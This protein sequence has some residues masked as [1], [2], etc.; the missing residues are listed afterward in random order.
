[1]SN[2]SYPYLWG[3]DRIN[4]PRLP[5]D[6]RTS[7]ASCY[8]AAGAGVHVFV[9][10]TG[11]TPSHEQF[12]HLGDRL[13]IRAAPG[14]AFPSGVDDGRHG[15]HVAATIAGAATG[16]APRVNLTCIKVLKAD[17]SGSSLDV[18]A[19]LDVVVAWAAAHPTVPAVLSASFGGRRRAGAPDM[20]AAAAARV[21]AAGVVFVGSAGN[22]GD[23][24]CAYTPAVEPSVVA[25]A[26]AAVDDS[27]AD[28]SN[29]GACV[30]L[31]APGTRIVSADAASA[32]GRGLVA[33]TGTSMAAPHVSGLAALV[34]GEVGRRL[35]LARLLPALNGGGVTAAGLPLAWVDPHVCDWGAL[36]GNGTEVV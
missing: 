22:E 36:R 21:T 33:M 8:P 27:L 32:D 9:L 15:T 4:Q 10:D 34:L 17:N 23:D 30:T 3:K 13:T 12:S 35:P 11:C 25:V 24:A 5:L 31:I 2:G 29:R 18:L 28:T 7:T 6:R 20:L 14:S 26:N 19:A 1:V 16:V